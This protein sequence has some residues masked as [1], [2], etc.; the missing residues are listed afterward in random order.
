MGGELLVNSYVTS[1]QRRPAVAMGGGGA[2]VVT[3]HSLGQDGSDDGIFARR[4]NPVGAPQAAEFQVNASTS[5]NQFYP[6]IALDRDGDFVVVW[7]GQGDDAAS[8]LG[9]FARGFNSAGAPQ[10]AEFQVNAYTTGDQ[11][12][13]GVGQA[14]NGDFVVA[15][16]S[17]GQDGSS[18]GIFA[19]RFDS[20]GAPQAAEFQVNTYTTGFQVYS[21][22]GVSMRRRLRRR[23]GRAKHRTATKRA[24]LPVGSTPWAF[25]RRPSSRVNSYTPF[26][27]SHPSV[28][29]D[30]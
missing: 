6:K 30:R 7:I 1:S 10:G 27:Q 22:V 17:R 20:A 12:L 28:G 26:S 4:F 25:P 2:F 29:L 23:L 5:K 21:A 24:S 9:I 3:W 15:W 16:T 11:S 14:A 8:S 13:P 19:R 18:Y